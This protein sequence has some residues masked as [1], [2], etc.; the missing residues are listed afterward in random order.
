MTTFELG[1]INGHYEDPKPNG[2][3]SDEKAIKINGV[4]GDFCSPKCTGT[5][6]PSD[7]PTGVTATPT[8]ALKTPFGAKYCA[9][10]CSPSAE[11][12]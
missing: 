5:E 4:T 8:C 9:L 7:V 2:C 3:G 11:D 10:I 6:C 1:D 12:N